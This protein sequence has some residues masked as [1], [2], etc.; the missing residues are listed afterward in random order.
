[1]FEDITER[2]S[3][4][5]DLKRLGYIF[6]WSL[7]EIYQF[8]SETLKFIHVNKAARGNLGYTMAE[9]KKMTPI[10]LKTEF[11][12][13][14]FK[15]LIDPLTKNKKLVFETIH[16][17]KDQSIYDVEVHLQLLDYGEKLIFT[18]IILDITDRK[19]VEKEKALL[20]KQF[21]KAQKME[22]VGRLAGGVAHDFNNA[23]SVIISTA[24]LAIDDV[25]PTGQLREDLDEILMAGKRAADITRQLL[26]FARKQA[27]SPKVLDLN[28]NV[29]DMLKMLRRL[30][31]ED[32]DLAWLPG[33]NPWLVNVD[34]TQID[35]ILANL[36]VN[37]RDAIEGVGKVT[38]DLKNITFTK[39]Y[40]ADHTG[41]IPGGFIQ[42]AVSDDGCGMNK[43]ILDNIF[44]PFFTTKDVDKGTGLGLATV[45][46]DQGF[47]FA[48]KP[49]FQN[50]PHLSL[51]VPIHFD[52]KKNDQEALYTD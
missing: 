31:G 46:C 35:Q 30:I 4:E 19:L 5:E 22:S 48:P 45:Y 3:S 10:D 42:L 17:R 44:E 43:E 37:A 1:L 52:T 34:P 47:V 36:C 8:E 41:F 24:E 39:D 32:I 13:D 33:V 21:Q 7:N 15:T 38:I 6:D 9:L 28:E 11:T 2:K 50:T 25:N 51:G 14:E 12:M 49:G 16:K 20:E 29:G 40:C 26:A 27:I 23:L 18:A